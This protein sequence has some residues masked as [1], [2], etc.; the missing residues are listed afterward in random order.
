MIGVIGV[1]LV[2][3]SVSGGAWWSPVGPK[4]RRTP[5]EIPSIGL[6]PFLP[7]RR[8]YRGSKERAETVINNSRPLAS[9]PHSTFFSLPEPREVVRRRARADQSELLSFGA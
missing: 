3:D 5:T 1:K 2:V 8:P 9:T 6:V 4:V 7:V